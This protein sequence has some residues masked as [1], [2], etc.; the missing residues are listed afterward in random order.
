[1]L[2]GLFS[3]R[4]PFG[5]VPK[6]L[7]VQSMVVPMGQ[8]YPQNTLPTSGTN[9]STTRAGIKAGSI[10]LPLMTVPAARAG[11]SLRKKFRFVLFGTERMTPKRRI[12][13]RERVITWID[14]LKSMSMRN[15]VQ[16]VRCTVY[17]LRCKVY[18]FF[19]FPLYLIPHTVFH[20]FRRKNRIRYSPVNPQLQQNF[21]Y[22]KL[23][24]IHSAQTP[25]VGLEDMC[26]L[27]W[28][29]APTIPREGRYCVCIRGDHIP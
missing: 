6:N 13:K 14:R 3:L 7:S 28:F 15:L 22:V 24:Y 27:S 8:R 2:N 21:L 20:I 5:R 29:I 17:G 25:F 10:I 19:W 4:R 1:M 16:G 12:K 23:F 11:S 9:T 18:R 26:D